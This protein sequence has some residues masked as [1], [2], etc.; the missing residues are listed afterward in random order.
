MN[1]LKMFRLSSLPFEPLTPPEGYSL[2]NYSAHKDKL[3][4]CECCKKG[5]VADDADEKAFDDSITNHDFVVPGTD[6]F[7]LDFNGEHIGTVTA[8]RRPYDNSGVLH[9]VGIRPDCRGR[10]LVKY[11]NNAGIG[12]LLKQGVDYIELT[13]DEWRKS[14]VKS[15]LSAGFLPV[16]Y[17]T[18]MVGR[19][20]SVLADIGV[21]ECDM[22]SDDRSFFKK[23]SVKG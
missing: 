14:A 3:A 23:I 5:L 16:N 18:D 9:M 22:L 8:F 12:K 2:S 11:L 19:W 21:D 10:G 17:D 13:T 6:V 7:F 4:W 15:Y 20:E 1:Q